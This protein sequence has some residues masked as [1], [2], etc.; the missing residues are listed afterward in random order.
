MVVEQPTFGVLGPLQV[1][2]PEGLLKIAGRKPRLLLASLLLDANQVVSADL[3]AEVLWPRARPSSAVA[4]LR[5]YVSSLRS[6]GVRIAAHPS[7]YAI[8]VTPAELDALRFEEL[9]AAARTAGRTDEGFRNLRD[10]LALW[11]GTPLSDLPAS[12]LW[13]TRLRSLAQARLAAVEELVAMKMARGEHAS[14]ID[15]LR[16]LIGEHPYREDL[17]QRLILALHQSGRRAEALHAYTT[18][19]RQLVDDLGIEPGQDLRDVH[20]S[21]LAGDPTPAEDVLTAPYQLP[22]DVPDFTGRALDVRALTAALL[23][24]PLRPGGPPSIAVVTGPPGVGKSA[25][26]VHC[27]HAV[28]AAYPAGQLYLCLGGTDADPAEPADLLAEALRA[29]GV[30]DAA[31]PPTVRERA[32]LYRSLL[33][34]R[35][36]LVLLDDAADTAQLRALLPGNGSA[37]L[38]TSRRRIAELPGSLQLELDVLP[39]AEA[40]QFLAKVAGPDRVARE[41][42]A[43]EAIVRACGYLPLAVRVAGARLAGRPGWSLNVLRHRLEDE[44]SRLDELRA[45]DLE[46]RGSFELSYRRLPGDAAMAFRALG[47]LG[48][49]SVPGWVADA[50][51]DRHRSEAVVDTLVDA[52]LLRLAG[53]D[54]AGQPRYRLHD[55]IRCAAR[56]KAGGDAERHALKRVLG[57]WQTAAERATAALP[58]TL[59][60][61]TPDVPRWSLEGETLAR[62]TAEP[63]PWLDA[64]RDSLVDAV[65]L[66]ADAGMAQSAWGLASTLVPY[67]DLHCRVEEWRETHRVAL[68]SARAA[69][70][71]YGEAAMLRG[72]AQVSLYQDRYTEA[73]DMFR[74]A[75]TIFRELGDARSEAISICGMGAVNQFSGRHFRALGSFRHA[76]AMFVATGDRSGEAYARQAIGRVYLSLRDARQASRWLGEA[77]RLAGELGDAHREG[78]VS[79]HLG[80]LYDLVAE[81]ERAMRCQGHA[82]DIF[83]SLGD[84]HCGAYAMRNLGGLQV[85]RGERTDGSDQLQR[86]LAIFQQLGDRSGVADTYQTLSELYRSAGRSTLATHYQ[87]QAR[88]LRRE[89]T[90]AYA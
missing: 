58:T 67:F 90:E 36:M 19:R 76:L 40:E 80:R 13:D 20:A 46:V 31:L 27:A 41:R 1:R 54:P 33:A 29:L 50:V 34:E 81:S 21:V 75:R 63:L 60:G 86:S 52:N 23:P 45:G 6:I 5:T 14:A 10:A 61:L 7:G 68:D 48:P 59:F 78:C 4:N 82:L 79:M 17:W 47:L 28:R 8:E 43:A 16:E 77:L 72:L 69:N 65:R 62:L 39:P 71:R 74:R 53:T 73:D 51:L 15:D 56:E 12:P 44:T 25:L 66:A 3:L 84:R 85:A 83:E 70:D 22:A 9:V 64:E 37:V 38:V 49:R 42:E 32:S 35:P 30:G 89:L 87:Y 57:G 18:I 55:L 88:E 26:A 24:D 11:R 2:V